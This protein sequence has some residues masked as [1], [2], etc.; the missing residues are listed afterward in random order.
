MTVYVD[1][2]MNHGWRLRGHLTKSCHLFTDELSLD[3][4]HAVAARI[5]CRHTWFQES[6][7]APHYDLTPA[8]RSNAIQLGAQ[9]VSRRVAVEIWRARRDLVN[10][11]ISR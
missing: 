4:L 11:A 9:E 6:N 7:T 5:G 1:P 8:R 10:E 3:A 2:L